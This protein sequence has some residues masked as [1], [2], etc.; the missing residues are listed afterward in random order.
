MVEVGA[1]HGH[2]QLMDFGGI[3]TAAMVL[4]AAALP[5]AIAAWSTSRA[6]QREIEQRIVER[7]EDRMERDAIAQKA[8][9]V[10]IQLL[11]NTKITTAAAIESNE[12]LDRLQEQG[13]ETHS[14][15][16]GKLERVERIAL[17]ALRELVR[18]NAA[19]GVNTDAET[20]ADLKELEEK[21]SIRVP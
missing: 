20:L 10:R 18:M 14:L 9:I 19:S 3:Q 6:K 1:I 15:V 21:E 11:K 17:K 4:I 13:V 16:N 5:P 12:K 2:S 7:N 8:E